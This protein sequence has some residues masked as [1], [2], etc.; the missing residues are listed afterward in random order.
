MNESGLIHMEFNEIVQNQINKQLTDKN[1][2]WH[3]P[4]SC[5][6]PVSLQKFGASLI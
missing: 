2:H 4:S 6:N 3:R 5:S 1:K